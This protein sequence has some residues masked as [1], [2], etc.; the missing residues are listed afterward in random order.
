VCSVCP[1]NF[2]QG[3]Y[4]QTSCLKCAEGQFADNEE[5]AECQ[6]CPVNQYLTISQGC[7]SCPTFGVVCSEGKLSNEINYYAYI[8]PST[9]I[10]TVFECPPSYCERGQCAQ[11]RKNIS[12]NL[13]CGECLEGFSPSGSGCVL[14]NGTN[15][16]AIVLF[17]VAIWIGVLAMTA[18]SR[19]HPSDNALFQILTYFVQ[20]G[21]LFLGPINTWSSWLLFLNLDLANTLSSVQGGSGSCVMPLSPYGNMVMGLAA[22]IGMCFML[23]FV[24]GYTKLWHKERWQIWNHL[25]TLT[26]IALFIY[27]PV[28]DTVLRYLNCVQ[29]GKVR[30]VASN[31]A[32]DCDS[33]QYSQWGAIVYLTLIFFV[34]G[35]PFGILYF[36]VRAKRKDLL[37]DN[38]FEHR[39]GILY[40]RF[41]ES[42]YWWVVVTLLRRT[43]LVALVAYIQ[44]RG[45]RYAAVSFFQL[46]FVLMQAKYNPFLL[47]SENTLAFLSLAF[48]LLLTIALGSYPF[49]YSVAVQAVVT[50]L[51]FLPA[52]GMV[53]Y[54]VYDKVR[55]QFFPTEREKNEIKSKCRVE[56]DPFSFSSYSPIFCRV[57]AGPAPRN[58][59]VQGSLR[60]C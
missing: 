51:I 23:L 21:M 40:H 59:Y 32:I 6:I 9:G 45:D 46:A 56:L 42:T 52:L 15:Y 30:V 3:D 22:P 31:P 39:Y 5:S 47:G 14:C 36:L 37:K 7:Q 17:I 54:M 58:S 16:V 49:P 10:A 13:L 1:K 55:Q 28:A 2:Y 4:G 11:N 25:R 8:E 35:G 41:R 50:L 48:L 33:P 60:W 12:I 26:S 34:A 20:M 27:T 57:E 53:V 38:D 43:I 19:P 44:K 24:M 29:V 18:M